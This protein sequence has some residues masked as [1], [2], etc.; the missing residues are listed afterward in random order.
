M[1]DL[2]KLIGGII[3]FFI[4]LS[5]I[6][7][8][9]PDSPCYQESANTTN[10]MGN[11]GL[12]DLQYSGSYTT[13]VPSYLFVNYTKPQEA[14][15]TSQW[16]VKFGSTAADSSHPILE[17]VSILSSCWDY[18]A[19]TLVLRLRSEYIA[20]GGDNIF[21]DGECFNGTDWTVITSV[22]QSQVNS[23]NYFYSSTNAINDGNWNTGTWYNTA[24]LDLSGS[25]TGGHFHFYSTLYEEAMLWDT[26]DVCTSNPINSSWTDWQNISCLLNEKMNQSKM[27]TEYDSNYGT[28]YAVTNLLSDLWNNGNNNTYFQFQAVENCYRDN[29]SDGYTSNTDCDDMNSAVYPFATEIC[30]GLDNDCDGSII[31]DGTDEA[32]YNSATSCGLGECNAAGVFT[33]SAGSQVNT[34]LPGMPAPE[35]C[36]GLDNDC[37]GAVDEGFSDNDLDG[38]KDC[39]D[40]DDDNDGVIDI[41]DNCVN[42]SNPDQ[43]DADADFLGNVCDVCADSATNDA[44]GDGYCAGATFLSPKIGAGDCNDN[45]STVNPAEIEIAG[46]GVD[47]NCDS[48]V[49]S[50]LNTTWSGFSDLSCAINQM[51]QSQFLI[52]YDS[53]SCGEVLNQ[54]IYDYQLVG[55][56]LQNTT[57]SSWENI[58][59]VS[60]DVMNQSRNLTQYDTYGCEVNTTIFEYQT[61]GTCDFCIPNW[62]NVS[63]TEW[64]NT[65][66]CNTDNT[67]NATMDIT[68]NDTNSCGEGTLAVSS[69]DIF[70]T[71]VES[72]SFNSRIITEIK[73]DTCDYCAPTWLCSNYDLITGDCLDCLDSS[74]CFDQTQ[75]PSD[76]YTNTTLSN[77]TINITINPV[78]NVTDAL[79]G[80]VL[81]NSTVTNDT[82]NSGTVNAIEIFI[83]NN[84]V[85]EWTT[86]TGA[87]EI[88]LTRGNSIIADF[89]YNFTNGTID[90]NNITIEQNN[91]NSAVKGYVILRGIDTSRLINQTKTLYMNRI[92]I[93][94]NWVCVKDAEINSKDEISDNCKGSDET[95]VQCNGQD[96]GGYTCTENTTTHQ[97]KITGLH[98]SGVTQ[99]ATPTCSDGIQNQDETGIDCGG[100]CSACSSTTTTTSSSSDDDSD[101]SN[102]HSN[103]LGILSVTPSASDLA[104]LAANQQ[105]PINLITGAAVGASGN[106]N[107]WIAMGF[108]VLAIAGFIALKIKLARKK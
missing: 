2:F 83:G 96:F 58:S 71:T 33:C 81:G 10:Q 23:W 57:W 29:D 49:T 91:N 11:D 108:V 37:D 42:I 76:N 12:C 89:D 56:T 106:N 32:W 86:V 78:Q 94:M 53:N 35:I 70:K 90:F 31:D 87:L 98:H 67:V 17:N 77:L 3:F 22:S 4:I 26:I 46:D 47:N 79:N 107:Y 97:Y 38:L 1:K 104:E 61:N 103:V 88:K 69:K 92:D 102:S 63:S 18:D 64:I 101:S 100:V 85:S 8:Y 45:N 80:T 93:S 73:T 24:W 15:G 9:I 99:T 75:H 27:M 50:L 16:K 34:C 51:N 41:N 13:D 30:D 72:P 105:T 21:A 5:F 7:A 25:D 60:G 40:P 48:C 59:C 43:S 95:H 44:D 20:S 65:T 19:N 84:P 66:E 55:P 36:D 52:Q 14:Q 28:C 6:N 39:V 82:F 68:Q 54:T 74:L 62:V